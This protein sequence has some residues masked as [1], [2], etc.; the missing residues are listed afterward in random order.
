MLFKHRTAHS[1]WAAAS[2]SPKACRLDAPDPAALAATFAISSTLDTPAAHHHCRCRSRMP[3]PQSSD[4][5]NPAIP[6][7]QRKDERRPW[8]ARAWRAQAS[9]APPGSKSQARDGQAVRS[10]LC[11][12]AASVRV[13]RTALD[14]PTVT[15]TPLNLAAQD[16]IDCPID[17]TSFPDALP[18]GCGTAAKPCSSSIEPRIPAAQ[19][20]AHRRKLVGSML[21]IQQHWP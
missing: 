6:A 4:A 10:I 9:R 1:S 19:R 15:R 17:D 3:F 11:W 2:L 14:P 21:L 20:P 13:T 7:V 16:Q 8:P 18:I 12:N 5:F